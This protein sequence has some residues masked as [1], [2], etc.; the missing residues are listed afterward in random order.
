MIFW[1]LDG[2]LVD[3]KP[4]ITGSVIKALTDLNLPAPNSD[5][6]EWVIG[7]ALLWSFEKLGAPDPEAALDAYR[8]HYTGGGMYDCSVYKGIPHVLEALTAQ[9]RMSIATAKPHAYARKITAHF[10]LAQYMTHEFG[11]ELD[12]TRNDK[13][14]LLAYALDITGDDPARCV[15]I[16]DRHY[17][18]KA[19]RANG[20]AFITAGWGYGGQDDLSTADAHVKTP[21]ELPG[22]I[23][24]LIK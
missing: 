15:M 2:T 6:L 20:M 17:D 18:L 3:P 8:K 21:S 13:A 5:D 24:S 7:P 12:G 14:E 11:P 19:A 4:G 9:F 16:G 1:D 23:A 10:D 22:V